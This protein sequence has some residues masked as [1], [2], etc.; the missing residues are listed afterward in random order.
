MCTH[1]NN[2]GKLFANHS[3][4]IK[5]HGRFCGGNKNWWSPPLPSQYNFQDNFD[6]SIVQNN[7]TKSGMMGIM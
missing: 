1:A 3:R 4:A 2:H 7:K 6:Q 5:D